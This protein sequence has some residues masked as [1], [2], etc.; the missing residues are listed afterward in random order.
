MSLTITTCK[1]NITD[2]EGEQVCRDCG[3]V[4]G[5][6]Q[7]ESIS[8]KDTHNIGMFGLSEYYAVASKLAKNLNLPQ[9]AIRTI[10]HTAIKLRKKNLPKKQAVLFATIYA[11]R[12]HEIPRLLEDIF[13]QLENSSGKR[14]RRSEK[15]LLRLLNK[16]SKNV[17]SEEFSLISPNKHYYHQAY[18]AKIQN[19]I[20]KET[21]DE[22]F[23][24]IRTRSFR[25]LQGIHAD[26][27]SSAKKAILNSTTSIIQSKIREVLS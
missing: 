10:V 7:V 19:V 8:D 3:S 2:I 9:F 24:T 25:M 18:L 4:L 15:S 22:Y 21:G 26:P 14:I 23:E 17:D 27:S 12:I 16:I 13:L 1:H 11:C 6:N 20:I 5:Y